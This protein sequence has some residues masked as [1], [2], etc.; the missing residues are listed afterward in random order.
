MKN[1]SS[2]YSS[3]R[4][5]MFTIIIFT[6][7]SCY[8]NPEI[9]ENNN[10]FTISTEKYP[11]SYGVIKDLGTN[12]EITG[13]FY[14]ISFKSSNSQLPENQLKFKILSTS[15]TRLNEGTY[16]FGRNEIGKFYNIELGYD[17]VYDQT[18]NAID[19]SRLY[20]DS[21]IN[22]GEIVISKVN[23]NYAFEIELNTSDTQYDVIGYFSDV[24]H[25]ETNY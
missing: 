5:F 22:N 18:Y 7:I 1:Y 24:L 13:R 17:L 15:T 11:I 2:K 10:Y 9:E 21:H 23:G 4:I 19:G 16:N 6:A 12:Y 25:D 14:E 20:L 8:E 3:T